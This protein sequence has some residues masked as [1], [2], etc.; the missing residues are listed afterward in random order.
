M[1]VRKRK[2]KSRKRLSIKA[3]IIK[4]PS[5]NANKV[6]KVPQMILLRIEEQ[7][8]KSLKVTRLTP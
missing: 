6:R 7:Q 1:K 8:Q 4:C 5:K 2:S 3:K